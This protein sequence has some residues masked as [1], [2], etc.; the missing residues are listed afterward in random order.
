MK[1]IKRGIM[2]AKPRF[3]SWCVIMGWWKNCV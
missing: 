3:K 2:K 1:D